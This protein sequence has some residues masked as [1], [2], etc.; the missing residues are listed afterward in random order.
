MTKKIICVILCVLS[1]ALAVNSFAAEQ[2]TTGQKAKNFWQKLFNYPAR[3]TEESAKT[4]AQTGTGAVNVVTQEVKKVGQ[5]TSGEIE[6]TPELITEPVQGTAETVK[7]TITQT[8]AIPV[9]ANTEP[10]EASGK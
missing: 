10:A 6:K 7:N 1:L 9:T 4:V 5:V 2:E 8:A 3:I